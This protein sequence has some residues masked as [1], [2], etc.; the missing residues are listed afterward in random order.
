MWSVVLAKRLGTFK[1]TL[2]AQIRKR[3]LEQPD[4]ID[5][6]LLCILLSLYTISCEFSKMDK[7]SLHECLCAS[8]Q[9]DIRAM[10]SVLSS[11]A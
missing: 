2:P 9:D 10:S 11:V 1:W 4:I 8:K 5:L 7:L 3:L 6:I